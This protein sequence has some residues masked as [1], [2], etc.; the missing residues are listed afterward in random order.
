[1]KLFLKSAAIRLWRAPLVKRFLKPIVVR[2][3]RAPSM[4]RLLNSVFHFH[5]VELQKN[6]TNAWDITADFEARSR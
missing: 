3:L 1:M 6:E 4:N 2:L 5:Q